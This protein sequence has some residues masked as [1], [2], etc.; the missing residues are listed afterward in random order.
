MNVFPFK[1]F[2]LR[3]TQARKRAKCPIGKCLLVR[4]LKQPRQ[5]FRLQD[6]DLSALHLCLGDRGNGI[7]AAPSLCKRELKKRAQTQAVGVASQRPNEER[8]Q[9]SLDLL[10]TDV[11]KEPITEGLLKTS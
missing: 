10:Y 3:A 2:Q 11:S 4:V 5:L 6:A 9:P 8:A 7:L 1:P